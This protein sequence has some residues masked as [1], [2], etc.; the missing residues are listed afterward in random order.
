MQMPFGKHQGMLIE[1]YRETIS[2]GLHERD[3]QNG[4]SVGN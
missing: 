1:T 3:F 2:T 4:K